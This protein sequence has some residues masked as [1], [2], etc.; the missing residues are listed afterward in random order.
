MPRR[1]RVA[2]GNY[3]YHVLNRAVGRT[4]IFETDDDYLAFL[5]VL[6]QA[7]E[8]AECRLLSF[9]IM[10]NHWHLVLWPKGDNDLSEYMRWLTVTHTQRW[11]SFHGTSG[12]GPIYQGRFKSFPIQANDHFYTA[13][14][15]VERNAL[16]ANLVKKAENWRW[17]SLWQSLNEPAVVILDRWPIPKPTQWTELVNKPQ[18]EA[19][20]IALQK[21]IKRGSPLGN[22]V[23]L[24]RTA[25]RLKLESTLRARGRP[26]RS[27]KRR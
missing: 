27:A 5:R 26:S 9:C 17:G 3:V 2:S 13:S 7:R 24:A 10:P 22:P 20:V 15:Y 11:H 21:S 4:T 14:R 8:K 23:W 12:T 16:N 6:N 18:T 1:P 19:E 25:K